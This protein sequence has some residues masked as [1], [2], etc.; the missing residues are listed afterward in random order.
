M[1]NQTKF[2]RDFAKSQRNFTIMSRIVISFITLV[3]IAI[4]TFWIFAGV[5]AVKAI[6]NVGE[7]GLRGS[8]EQLWC[9]KSADCK[10]PEIT[11]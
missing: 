10:L 3:F 6:D 11:K 9:G 5:F 1:F 8:L 2:D 4:I 7:Q